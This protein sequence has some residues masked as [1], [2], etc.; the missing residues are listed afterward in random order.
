MKNKP[1]EEYGQKISEEDFDK[2][3]LIFLKKR[4]KPIVLI[5]GPSCTG[6]STVIKQLSYDPEYKAIRRLTTKTFTSIDADIDYDFVS[7]EVFLDKVRSQ[8]FI[9]WGKYKSG[10]YGTLF[11]SLIEKDDFSKILLINLDIRAAL[12]LKSLFK[13]TN[14]LF[15]DVLILPDE[16][17]ERSISIIKSRLVYRARDSDLDDIKGR[18]ELAKTIINDH[19]SSFRHVLYNKQGKINESIEFLKKIIK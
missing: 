17:K 18:I 6:K 7:D 13:K 14:I 19:V 2:S 4:K 10:Y 1:L 5:T 8:S 15:Y 9:E 3:K 16:N 12:M 11:D